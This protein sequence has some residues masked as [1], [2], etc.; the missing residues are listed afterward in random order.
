MEKLSFYFKRKICFFQF[1]RIVKQ[2][3]VNLCI[4]FSIIWDMM[5]KEYFFLEKRKH[6]WKWWKRKTLSMR[7]NENI[8]TKSKT[9]ILIKSYFVQT[10]YLYRI[11]Q[12]I[13]IQSD[14]HSSDMSNNKEKNDSKNKYLPLE[15][16][17]WAVKDQAKHRMIVDILNKSLEGIINLLFAIFPTEPNHGLVSFQINPKECRPHSYSTKGRT[18]KVWWNPKTDS[19]WLCWTSNNDE[20]NIVLEILETLFLTH[21]LHHQSFDLKRF[22]SNHTV[23]MFECVCVCLIHIMYSISSSKWKLGDFSIPL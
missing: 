6:K 5:F 3:L 22:D 16:E 12:T 15:V 17:R 8:Q 10:L 1:W 9:E 20:K 14:I 2:C 19:A 18:T 23:D 11:L 4:F 13:W 7:W 21:S